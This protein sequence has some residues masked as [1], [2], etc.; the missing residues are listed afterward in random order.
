MN[1]F[2]T[3]EDSKVFDL[4][5]SENERQETGLELIAQKT[6]LVQQL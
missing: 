6:T 3:Q 2:P 1:N 5:N 4:I